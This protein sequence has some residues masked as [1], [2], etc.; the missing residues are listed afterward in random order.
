[1]KGFFPG[2]KLIIQG[3]IP[4]QD[5]FSL[6]PG[7][8]QDRIGHLFS[9]LKDPTVNEQNVLGQLIKLTNLQNGIER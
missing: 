6:E 1:M 5:E 9:V 7:L 2:Q 3:P 8:G 4:G